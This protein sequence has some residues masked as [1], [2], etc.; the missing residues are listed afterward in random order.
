MPVMDGFAATRAIRELPVFAGLPII[1]MTANA[2][3]SDRDDC[4]AAGMN[5][6][7][8]KP[9]ELS[10]LVKTLLSVSG[11]VAPASSA[12]NTPA[13][14]PASAPPSVRDAA[15]TARIGGI[16]FDNALTRLSGMESLYLRA[17]KNFCKVI[18]TVMEE[19]RPLLQA[20]RK[21]ASLQMHTLKGNAGLLGALALAELTGQLEKLCACGASADEIA[22][23]MAQLKR[24]LQATHIDLQAVITQLEETAQ[25]AADVSD[26]SDANASTGTGTPKNCDNGR[27]AMPALPVRLEALSAMLSCSDLEALS[28]FAELRAQLP[29][30]LQGQLD[31]LEGALQNLELEEAHR[32]LLDLMKKLEQL[33]KDG[34]V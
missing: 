24:T 29:A 8:G 5:A 15:A 25:K 26:E 23:P 20:D 6:H 22:A 33:S 3:D 17:A 10:A 32:H 9:F 16:D 18:P 14:T 27:D 13:S 19:F 34:G 4:L 1:A 28:L 30:Q 31:P 21:Q 12:A 11:Y 2:M 7:V